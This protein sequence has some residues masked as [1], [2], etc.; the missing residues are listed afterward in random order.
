M[1]RKD[2]ILD[3]RQQDALLAL[4]R[5]AI[6][7][8]VGAT[9]TREQAAD[10][11][12]PRLNAP[13]AAFVTLTQKGILRGCIGH[14]QAVEALRDSV[15]NNAINAALHDPRFPPLAAAELAATR[16]EISVLSAPQP[17]VCA[18]ADELLR[19][20]AGERPGLIL[21][22]GSGHRATFLPQVWEQL[23][24]PVDFLAALCRKAGLPPDAWKGGT[25]R[26][27]R[28]GVQHFEEST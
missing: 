23:P 12:D 3:A 28:Y 9:G 18:D 14:L 24:N 8:A 1:E 17:L 19:V 13:G 21:T 26:F 15:R 10:T 20:L 25:L 16:I 4:A 11:D 2:D 27:Q 22:D 6:A 5:S 7:R